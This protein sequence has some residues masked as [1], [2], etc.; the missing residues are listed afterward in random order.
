MHVLNVVVLLLDNNGNNNNSWSMQLEIS[1]GLWFDKKWG[2]K[3]NRNVSMNMSYR[4]NVFAY[5]TIRAVG[6]NGYGAWSDWFRTISPIWHYP[7]TD[8]SCAEIT[9]KSVCS[10]HCS[11]FI[12]FVQLQLSPSLSVSL[13][14]RL[15]DL[16][17]IFRILENVYY[18]CSLLLQVLTKRAHTHTHTVLWYQPNEKRLSKMSNTKTNLKWMQHQHIF[19]VPIKRL[20]THKRRGKKPS[21]NEMTTVKC[22]ILWND[23]VFRQSMGM[24]YLF[25]T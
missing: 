8:Q 23:H 13:Y 16:N 25:I 3:L 19:S 11:L 6:F 24:V 15:R 4:W 2:R 20:C 5:D 12:I 10:A 9:T 22:T 14:L 1:I 21:G 18:L 17:S 7:S